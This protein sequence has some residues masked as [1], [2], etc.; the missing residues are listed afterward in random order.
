MKTNWEGKGDPSPQCCDF[1]PFHFLRD[2][3]LF[4]GRLLC[5][6]FSVQF[7]EAQIF[8]WLFVLL[9]QH[10]GLLVHHHQLPSSPKLKI[11]EVSDAIKKPSKYTLSSPSP[12]HDNLP[13]GYCQK[14][15]QTNTL[16]ITF[17]DILLS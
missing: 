7:I 10:S 5:S 3:P 6:L 11:I 12:L 15:R 9:M 4:P 13:A 2:Y 1:H 16:D 14:H 8:I 17:I